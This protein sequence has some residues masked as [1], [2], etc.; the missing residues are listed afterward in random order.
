LVSAHKKD[1]RKDSSERIGIFV[2]HCG[3]NI[4]DTVDVERVSEI[5]REHPSVVHSEHYDYM[6]SQQ[7]QELIKRAINEYDLTSVVVA[8]CS[9]SLHELTF[10]DVV[11]RA[12]LNRYK[13]E[14]A[15]IRE[16]DS[17]VHEDREEA[18][19]KAVRIT[20]SIVEKVKMNSELFPIKVS[21][22]KKALVVG[23]GIA[24]I[25]A[26]LD[27][28]DAGYEVLLVERQPTIGGHMAK[29]AETF[30][31]LDC[32]SCILTP[33][34][35]EVSNHPKI[36]LFT[37][38]EI[39]S[40]EGYVGNFHVKIIKKPTY[41]EPGLCNLC[42]ECE[43]VC[44][45]F[46]L[47]EFDEGLAYRKAIYIPFPQAIPSTYTIDMDTC[48]NP[49]GMKIIACK[50]CEEV[51]EA[52]AINYDQKPEIVEEDVGVIIIAT[53][54]ELYSPRNIGEYGGGI[55]PDVITS[56]QFERLLSPNGPTN[57]I[58]KRLSDGKIPKKIAFIHCAGSRDENHND[59]CSGICCMYSSKHALLFH[60]QF[61]DAEVYNFYID[62][63]ASGKNYEQFIRRVQEEAGVNYIRGKVSRIFE[64]N[65]QVTIFGIDTLKGERIEDQFDMVVL[66]LSIIAP[67]GIRDLAAKLGVQ[68]DQYGWINEEHPKLRPVETPTSGI[69]VAGVA[70]GPKDIQ[71]TVAQASGA[72]SKALD[73][74]SHH[75]ISHIPTVAHVDK[76]FCCGCRLCINVCPYGAI[77]IENN[78]ARIK[79]VLCKGCGSCASICP[80]G[81]IELANMVDTQVMS[82]IDVIA[83]GYD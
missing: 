83:G 8:A 66:A 4:S 51:C 71:T 42:A 19:E 15:N 41:I 9:P 22:H 53:G 63:R 60:E 5:I 24:G 33:R 55:Y 49:K 1:L 52:K 34:M 20:R 77:T 31:T 54:Y 35:S 76:N 2:C 40:V 14:I 45:E 29:L 73:I 74:L 7:G 64:Q 68:Y 44:P 37:H 78:K 69:F 70:H 32:A 27:I 81:A 62:L 75:K 28:A 46:A 23:G 79:E 50:K 59:Y 11:E 17:W 48:L 30:P 18:T 13:C 36:N 43:D 3:R 26:A 21:L 80:C 82:M 38:S 58:P 56:L 12:G 25:Q 61:P 6:C 10:R 65:G 57:G 16:Q 72:A 47:S 39:I 67:K